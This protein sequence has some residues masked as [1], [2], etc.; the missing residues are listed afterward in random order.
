MKY[1]TIEKRIKTVKK[2]G[3][4]ITFKEPFYPEGTL[5]KERRQI[6]V[7][8]LEKSAGYVRIVGHFYDSNWYPNLNAL[9]D[10]IDWE[11]MEYHHCD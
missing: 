8:R 6:I 3:N 11:W 9:L 4:I 7:I 2:K 5:N 10:S 1:D